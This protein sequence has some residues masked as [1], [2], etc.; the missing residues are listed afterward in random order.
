MRIVLASS[1]AVPFAK[2]GGLAD[3][4][5]ALAKAL[6]ELGHQVWVIIPHYPQQLPRN[7]SPAIEPANISFPVPIGTRAADARILWSTLPGSQVTVLHVDQPAYFNRPSLYNEGGRDYADNCERFCFFSRAVVETCRRMVL[8]PDVIHANDWQTALIP[9]LLKAEHRNTTGL[10]HTGAVLT[11]HNMAFQGRFWHWDMHL[12]GLDWKYFNWRQME[13]YG[14][15]NLMKTGIVFSDMVTTVSP[16]YAREIQTPEGGCGLNGVLTSHRDSLVGILNGVDPDDW[17]P[18]TDPH[19]ARNFNV[20]TVA[21][22][23][24]ACKAWLQTHLG[25]PVRADVPMFGLISRMADQKGLDILGQCLDDVLQEDVQM[26]FLGT[27]ERHYEEMLV[28]KQQQYPQKVATRIGFNEGLAHQIEAGIDAFLMPSRYEPC[29]LNQMYSLIYGSVPVVRTVG[30]L[31]DS[32][33]DTTP[34]TLANRTATGFR[35]DEYSS[36]ALK[37]TIFR[38]LEAYRNRATW[39]Q[40][41]RTGMSQDCS[42]GRSAKEYVRVYEQAQAK[43]A[44]RPTDE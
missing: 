37:R 22:G 26:A 29:G 30:G 32:V 44:A 34:E 36:D 23:K 11:I 35:F 31:A 25:L 10:S 3:V 21:E 5:S 14:Q 18:A 4:V 43:S 15:L 1:E 28:A 42:W 9:A 12:T 39:T 27:G 24:P 7:L 16:T 19:L 41:M 8:R 2:T 13:A 20:A 40:L 33:V 38:T 6:A 17:N